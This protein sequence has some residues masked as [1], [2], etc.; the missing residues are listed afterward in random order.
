MRILKR[1]KGNKDYF[2]LQHSMRSDGK[3][4]TKE[5][6]LGTKIPA[7][8]K[9]LISEF[10]KEA[11]P[12]ISKK[13][14]AIKKNFQTEWKRV[15]YSVRKNELEEIS[16]AFTYNT[17]A[18]EGSTITLEEARE[19][20]HDKI[21]PNKPLRDV[22]ETEAHSKVFLNALEKKEEITNELLLRWHED[23]FGKTKQDIAGRY[24]DY[25]VRI[26]SYIA[27]DWQDVQELMDELIKFIKA[28]EKIN[29]VEL[30]ARVHYKFEKVH[31]FGDGNGRIGRLLMN[32]I[33]WH[34]G[35]PMLIIE[36][37]RRKSYYRALEKGEEAFVQYFLRRYLTI[38]KKRYPA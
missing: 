26:G 35:Y 27:P 14:E 18:I 6:Y 13:L 34:S 29:P 3:V 19:I 36:Y 37:K 2:Y 20:I 16:I 23:I 33:L 24:R 1:K 21:A 8:V 38:H 28:R 30:S 31:P 12:D 10:K 5:K 25:L 4:I 15:P 32:Y 7:N 22:G 11:M 17:N 9:E